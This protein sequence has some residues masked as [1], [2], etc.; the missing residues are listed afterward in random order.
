MITQADRY[1]RGNLYRLTASQIVGMIE[2]C[3]SET[4]SERVKLVFICK[5]IKLSTS[6]SGKMQELV[7]QQCSGQWPFVFVADRALTN[8]VL[9]GT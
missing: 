1:L 7:S 2:C 6:T 9:T 4:D 5:K 8:K 3:V